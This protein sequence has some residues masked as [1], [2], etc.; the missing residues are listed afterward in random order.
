MH[1]WLLPMTPKGKQTMNA[2]SVYAKCTVTY[3]TEFRSMLA[4]REHAG[5]PH[6]ILLKRRDSW[7]TADP[8]MHP[9]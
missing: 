6:D 2:S 8:L 3:A 1:E 4:K 7:Q 9:E 5:L